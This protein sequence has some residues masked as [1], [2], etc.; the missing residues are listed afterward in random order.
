MAKARGLHPRLEKMAILL[1]RLCKAKGILIRV[2]QA[3]RCSKEQDALYAQGRTTAGKIV[4]HAKGGES[5]HN[6]GL[7]FDIA[8][9][10]IVNG[11][12][13]VTWDENA[14]TNGNGEPDY[15]EVGTYGE[16]LGLEWGGRF[17]HPDKPHF[18][19][20]FGLSIEELKAG[21]RPEGFVPAEVPEKQEA[22]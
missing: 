1:I 10:K 11:D 13:F 14:D 20:T 22:A 6:Y 4:T 16:A 8:I 5:Y 7:A 19:Y 12:N 9:E 15:S 18:Q 2:T 3:Y 21:K 17:L